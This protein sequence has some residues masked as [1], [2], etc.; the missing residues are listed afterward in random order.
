MRL[1]IGLVLMGLFVPGALF[2][3]LPL[4]SAGQFFAVSATC[5]LCWGVADFLANIL[6]RPRIENYT[7]G[8][9]LREWE[10]SRKEET[11]ETGDQKPRDLPR[12]D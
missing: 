9:A 8:R 2:I 6:A 11:I 10:S 3:L 4:H 7:P 5:F 1:L 12:S